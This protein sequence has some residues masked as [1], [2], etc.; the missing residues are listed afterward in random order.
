MSINV[1]EL[2]TNQI[3]EQLENNIVPGE[4]VEWHVGWR[5]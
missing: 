3:I 1:Y 4:A 5:I 2:V